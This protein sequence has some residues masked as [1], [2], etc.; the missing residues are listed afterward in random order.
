MDQCEKVN[1]AGYVVKNLVQA[2]TDYGD[3]SA[4]YGLF[5]SL[6]KKLCYTVDKYGKLSEKKTFERY[7]ES[8][9]L[10]NTE[11]YFK[12]KN[13]ETVNGEFAPTWKRSFCHGITIDKKETAFEEFKSNLNELK[14][15]PPDE[16]GN[17]LPHYVEWMG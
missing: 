10:L 11:N 1:D 15:L 8:E 13:R 12:L 4:L 14:P 6:K 9:T 17:M 2:G 3:G 5:I 16:I 7:H